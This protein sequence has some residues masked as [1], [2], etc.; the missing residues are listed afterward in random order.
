MV[1]I[2]SR[3]YNVKETRME[4]SR[5]CNIQRR[6]VH[7]GKTEGSRVTVRQAILAG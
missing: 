4:Y 2:M 6:M 3:V 7:L 1:Q 5:H